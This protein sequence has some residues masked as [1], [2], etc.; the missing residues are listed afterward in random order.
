MTARKGK[1]FH[2]IVASEGEEDDRPEDDV[3]EFGVGNENWAA[4]KRVADPKWR[5]KVAASA[6]STAPGIHAPMAQKLSSHFP[7]FKPRIFRMVI[8]ASQP[9]AKS[10]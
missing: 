9:S 4:A 2:P 5:A 7:S 6:S 8:R 3:P 1:G 10:M